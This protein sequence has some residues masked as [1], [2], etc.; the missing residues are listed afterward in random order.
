MDDIIPEFDLALCELFIDNNSDFED[1]VLT[2]LRVYILQLKNNIIHII[3][4]NITTKEPDEIDF[5]K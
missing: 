1:R 5:L 3:Y 4:D 2:D